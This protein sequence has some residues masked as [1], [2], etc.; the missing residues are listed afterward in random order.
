M[1]AYETHFHLGWKWSIRLWNDDVRADQVVSFLK[2]TQW[3]P[4]KLAK[5]VADNTSSDFLIGRTDD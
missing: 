2:Q 3:L 4:Q 1:A 5:Q